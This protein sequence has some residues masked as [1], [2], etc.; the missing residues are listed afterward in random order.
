MPDRTVGVMPELRK[1]TA[2]HVEQALVE[3][4]RIGREEFLD[5]YGFRPS[6]TYVLRH[7][8]R[9]YDSK[10]V[11]GV[12]HRYATGRAARSKEFSGG[13]NGAARVLTDLGFE[14]VPG[15]RP[16]DAAAVLAQGTR[17]VRPAELADLPPERLD[18]PGLY[19]WFVDRDGAAELSSG[20]GHEITPGLLYVGQ[21]GATK[22]PSGT[23]SRSTLRKRLAGQH[24]RGR[25]SASTFRRT[26]GAVLDEARGTTTARGELTAWIHGHLSVVPL[27]VEDADTLGELEEQVVRS[28]CPPLNLDHSGPSDVRTR[29]RGLRA[30]AAT[31][32]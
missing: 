23:P 29:L 27:L 2:E 26:L 12:A 5:Q 15:S 9:E 28:L 14:V 30:R 6:R 31:V 4:D 10:A 3:H 21:A 19:S 17:A 8:G 1:I 11:V 22:W 25:R 32:D 13:L 18:G 20:L 7:A 24:V 16:R